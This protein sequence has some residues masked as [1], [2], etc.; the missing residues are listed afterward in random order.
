MPRAKK[1]SFRVEVWSRSKDGK[2]S[3]YLDEFYDIK[4]RHAP[5][6]ELLVTRK[7]IPQ[8]RHAGIWLRILPLG[9]DR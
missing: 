9:A 7:H 3:K 1:R 2:R 8:E 5:E 4:A 6:A